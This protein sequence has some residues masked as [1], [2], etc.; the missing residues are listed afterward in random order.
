MIVDGNILWLEA[1]CNPVHDDT[2]ELYKVIK[3]A[4]VIT[5]K[6]NREIGKTSEIAFNISRKTDENADLGLNVIGITI[7]KVT[8]LSEGLV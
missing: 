1:S 7:E 2:G 4:T 8:T 5:E 3:F 6:M